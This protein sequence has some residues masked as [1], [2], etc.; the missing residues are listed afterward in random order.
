VTVVGVSFDAPGRNESW[1]EAEGFTFDL[2]TDDHT[3]A[4]YYGAAA[5]QTTAR[6]ARKTYILDADGVEVLEYLDANADLG[7]HP[8]HV[9]HDCEVLF[10]G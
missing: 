8:A 3:L 10:S 6:A 1:A 9:L 7:E 5:S 4:L 2:W